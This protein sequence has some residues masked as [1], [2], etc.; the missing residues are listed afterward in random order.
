MPIKPVFVCLMTHPPSLS[1]WAPAK[2]PSAVLWGEDKAMPCLHM[3]EEGYRGN[4]SFQTSFS[5]STWRCL[6]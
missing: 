2:A 1:C 3:G 6:V 5:S 4:Q